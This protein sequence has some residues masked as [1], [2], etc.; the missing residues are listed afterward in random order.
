MALALGQAKYKNASSTVKDTDLPNP[1]PF[2]HRD[3]S[4][5]SQ[6]QMLLQVS[7]MMLT[8][9]TA[10][11]NAEESSD[12]S[13]PCLPEAKLAAENTF[14]K[15]CDRLEKIIADEPRWSDEYQK[16]LERLYTEQHEE[17]MKTFKAQRQAAENQH[18]AAELQAQNLTEL[19]TPHFKYKPALLKLEDGK[20]MALLGDAADA[21]S[22]IVGVGDSPAEAIKSFDEFFQGSIPDPLRAWLHRRQLDLEHGRET[23]PFPKNYA[24]TQ[25]VDSIGNRQVEGIEIIGAEQP[26]D[27]QG[28]GPGS[29]S[30]GEQNPPGVEPNPTH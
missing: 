19:L 6:L 15:V 24:T 13:T 30:G 28:P 26:T 12:G 17:R 2:L 4:T 3:I 27:G 9:L 10:V 16:S 1:V 29:S 20:F 8:A 14:I 22:G 18:R 5:Q 25:T 21:Q 11:Q 7:G 23:E